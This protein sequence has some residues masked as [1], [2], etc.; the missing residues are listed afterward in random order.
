[1]VIYKMMGMRNFIVPNDTLLYIA[2]RFTSVKF[3]RHFE[4][5]KNTMIKNYRQNRR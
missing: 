3:Y 5:I 4:V 2:E 1:M